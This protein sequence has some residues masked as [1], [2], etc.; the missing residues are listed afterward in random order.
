MLLVLDDS[1]KNALDQNV[2]LEALENIALGRREGK[3]LIFSNRKTL[4]SFK[5]CSSLSTRTRQVYLKL[6]TQFPELPHPQTFVRR[7]EVVALD[8]GL[9]SRMEGH[10]KVISIPAHYFCDSALIQKTLLLTENLDDA[11]F[12]KTIAEIYLRWKKL[13][14]KITILLDPYLGGGST[15]VTAYKLIQ[16]NQERFCLCFLDSDKKSSSSPFGN[17]AKNVVA[18]DDPNKPFCEYFVIGVREIEN[19]IPTRLYS[20]ISSGDPNRMAGVNFLERLEKSTLTEA[21]KYLDIKKGLKLG[22]ILSASSNTPFSTDWLN[23]L[24][25]LYPLAI[26][27]SKT[28]LND[29]VC[30]KSENCD[31]II[32]TGLGDNILK[33]VVEQIEKPTQYQLREPKIAKM[34]DQLLKPEWEKIGEII[35]AWCCGTRKMIQ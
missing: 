4:E 27:I 12:Y 23:G 5:N 21:R 13:K 14:K 19:L 15:T 24:N 8:S 6:Y 25:D 26:S 30:L 7:V 33:T 29:Q 20:E 11:T 1:L 2:V 18:I 22:E 9:S 3:H 16:N 35:T 32:T 10:C 17:T 34:V 31:C 28:C